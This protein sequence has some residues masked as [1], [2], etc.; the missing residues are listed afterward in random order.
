MFLVLL[1]TVIY[2]ILAIV[3]ASHFE[4]WLDTLL[5]TLSVG[6]HS[7]FLRS[8]AI[9]FNACLVLACHLLH[10]LDRRALDLSERAVVELQCR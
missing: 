4:S 9:Y 10:H 7:V 2:V 6:L 1:G 8:K 5:V 3:G